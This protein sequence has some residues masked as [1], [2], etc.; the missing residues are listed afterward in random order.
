MA[1][2]ED[3]IFEWG[4]VSTHR[5]LFQLASTKNIP[6]KHVGLVQNGQLV[7]VIESHRT[8]THSLITDMTV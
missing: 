6:I 2:N 4:N 7:L 1:Q 5:L 3:N 8:V